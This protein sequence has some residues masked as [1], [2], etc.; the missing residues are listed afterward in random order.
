MAEEG[1]GARASN[2]GPKAKAKK[3]AAARCTGWGS[4]ADEGEYCIH[5]SGEYGPDMAGETASRAEWKAGDEQAIGWW[6][7][8]KHDVNLYTKGDRI[9]K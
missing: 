7:G 8:E 5:Y 2:E 3:V 4:E 9:P 1:E 6:G